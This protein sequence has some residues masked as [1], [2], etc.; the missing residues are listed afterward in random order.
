[1]I[2]Q[3]NYNEDI[4]NRDIGTIVEV[5]NDNKVSYGLID[6][7]GKYIAINYAVLQVLELGYATTIHKSQ[8]SQ[9]DNFIIVLPQHSKFMC[10]KSILYTEI[11]RASLTLSIFGELK[12]FNHS[13]HI[14]SIGKTNLNYH[15]NLYSH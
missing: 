10:N 6:I 7:N 9:W 15:L 3:N 5:Y 8:G 14:Q 1:M 13:I 2:T 4:R 11:T 12:L